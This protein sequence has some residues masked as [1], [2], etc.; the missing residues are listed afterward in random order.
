MAINYDPKAL[1]KKVA[2][3]R[4]IKKLLSKNLTVKRAALNFAAGLDF[5]NPDKVAEIALKTVSDYQQ[6]VLKAES[7][8]DYDLEKK[9]LRNPAQLIQRIQN[10]LVFE[11]SKK[12]KENYKGERY[13]W[14]PS[15]AEEPDPLHQLNYG[16]VFVVGDGEMPGDRWGCRC[17]MRIL[18][19]DEQLDLE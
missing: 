14:L 10:S 18:T 17:G 5:I 12:I 2:P 15:D 4:K 8:G 9:L 13:Q 19:E 6:R 3:E 7:E 1:L 16:K 11:V